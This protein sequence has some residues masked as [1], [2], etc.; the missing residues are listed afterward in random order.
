MKI[1]EKI[2]IELY[3]A[4]KTDAELGELFGASERSIERYASKLRR[5]G[6]IKYRKDL[7]G[8]GKIPSYK[9]GEIFE[10]V[11][12]YI[13]SASS[14][15]KK[16]NDIYKNVKFKGTWKGNKQVE[17]MAL[18]WSDMHTGSINKSPI[19]GK[20]TYNEEIQEKELEALLRGVIRFYYLYRPSYKVETL[21]IF[22]AGD[23][24]T[25]DRIYEGQK[26][27]I[28]CNVGEQIIKTFEYQSSFIKKM[29]EIFPRVVF[30]KE[31][32][33]HGRTS[34]TPIAERA[35]NNFEYLLGKLLEERFKDNK[36]VEIIVPEN[37]YHVINIRGHKYLLFH[38]NNIRGTTLNTIEN[39]TKQIA[40]L[41]GREVYDVIIIGHFHTSLKLRI[42]PS[43]TL[44]VNGC[45]IHDDEYSYNKLR[46]F[47][48]ATQYL[49][50]I[51]KRS[52]L[53]NLQEIYLK[54]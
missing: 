41:A 5:E 10:E 46:K 11:Q 16:Y 25:N 36:R 18:V 21:Y 43:T 54:W 22:D 53:H 33:N 40:L 37:Y 50:N 39:A 49:F 15:I 44:L 13:D 12:Q 4:G 31:Y 26:S 52:A 45:F 38:G 1:N 47:S 2:F 29:L 27:E 30:I 32:G 35:T 42:T 7:F 51:S 9:N 34:P 14:V 20:I 3:N 6:K 8:N 28:T 48:S 19:T 23:N 24:I 17:D